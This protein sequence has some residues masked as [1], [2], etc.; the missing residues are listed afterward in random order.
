MAA[1]PVGWRSAGG[2]D[3]T[4][5]PLPSRLAVTA[6]ASF[7]GLPR[8]YTADASGYGLPFDHHGRCD[9]EGHGRHGDHQR[10]HWLGG[11][12]LG[13]GSGLAP[14]AGLTPA[15]GA[16]A[17]AVPPGGPV[18]RR[19]RARRRRWSGSPAPAPARVPA[20]RP[21]PRGC[22][23]APARAGSSPAPP[24]TPW[25]PCPAPPARHPAGA[26]PRR[27]AADRRLRRPGPPRRPP[28][29]RRPPCPA[30]AP[31]GRASPAARRRPRYRTASATSDS[32]RR[33]TPHPYPLP[34]FGGA[35]AN[36][37]FGEPYRAPSPLRV[38]A[39]APRSGKKVRVR[40]L[41]HGRN[42]SHSMVPGG[43]DVMS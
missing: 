11:G 17:A 26:H 8:R 38:F 28:P 41:R 32:S 14:A 6:C 34:A 9:F 1:R 24:S 15:A 2:F 37:P 5:R 7:G 29:S 42:H 13:A 4:R 22:A 25:P 21:P 10:W 27:A 31:A 23:C 19:G 20:P 43:F 3:S 36:K 33:R 39:L 35:R 12:G 16:G 30:G 18:A 40:G